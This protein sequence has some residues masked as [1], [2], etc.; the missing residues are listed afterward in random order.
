[1]HYTCGQLPNCIHI[2][3]IVVISVNVM[4]C[5]WSKVPSVHN[6]NFCPRYSVVYWP[7]PLPFCETLSPG[8][9]DC[10]QSPF[11]PL[12][13]CSTINH[14]KDDQWG[15]PWANVPHLHHWEHAHSNREGRLPASRLQ[16]CNKTR[17]VIR[18][19]APCSLD[20]SVPPVWSPL[21]LICRSY[22]ITASIA[23]SHTR[24]AAPNTSPA[25]PF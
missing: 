14:I 24:R 13:S 19:P 22:L 9:C 6:A 16:A 4:S 11:T 1:M 7:F 3:S 21:P 2:N 8:A 5:V 18:W 25:S 17:S 12:P 20:R 23:V 10:S 15:G